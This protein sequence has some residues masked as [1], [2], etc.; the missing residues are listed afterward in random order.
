MLPLMFAA[1]VDTIVAPP[2]DF[3]IAYVHE[4]G[5]VT[6]TEEVVHFGTGP[7]AFPDIFTDVTEPDIWDEPVARAPVVYFYG[8]PFTGTFT[9]TVPD[10]EFIET[11]PEPRFPEPPVQADSDGGGASVAR[12]RITSDPYLG[13]DGF[14]SP[15]SGCIPADLHG[16][17]RWPGSNTLLF[18][19]G[20]AESFIYYE[21]SLDREICGEYWDRLRV[22]GDP[23]Y[24][25]EDT[26]PMIRFEVLSTG[27]V[28]AEIFGSGEEEMEMRRSIHPIMDRESILET[29]CSWS[30]GTMKSEEISA[31]WETWEDWIMSGDWSGDVLLLFPLPSEVVESMSTISLDTGENLQIEYTRFYIGVA[32]I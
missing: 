17:W 32:S 28:A 31:M 5:A 4:W 25:P 13:R 7:E 2:P 24:H 27:T 30:G 6:F 12:W 22:G 11:V 15:G 16:A 10:G 18:D 20:S 29:L 23:A 9:V 1:L 14:E 26:P 3:N 21:C 8:A 19:D